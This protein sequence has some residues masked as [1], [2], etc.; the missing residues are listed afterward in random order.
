[1]AQLSEWLKV[2]SHVTGFLY[3][4]MY[5]HM[6]KYALFFRAGR[7]GPVSFRSE[8]YGGQNRGY[9]VFQHNKEQ[10]I[11]VAVSVDLYDDSVTFLYESQRRAGEPNPPLD[12]Y[13]GVPEMTETHREFYDWIGPIIAAMRKNWYN[14]M[15]CLSYMPQ[16]S[17]TESGSH[18]RLDHRVGS[19]DGVYG[20]RQAIAE[21]LK[22]SGPTFQQHLDR[23]RHVSSARIEVLLVMHCGEKTLLEHTE[24]PVDDASALHLDKIDAHIKQFVFYRSLVMGCDVSACVI[25]RVS[26]VAEQDVVKARAAEK[27][28]ADHV[29]REQADDVVDMVT[30]FL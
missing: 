5:R 21:F 18:I 8:Q 17:I 12:A 4:H 27:E 11:R 3:N 14:S 29:L 26:M 2:D 15:L 23:L 16:T 20:G 7:F 19:K 13:G 1:M 25:R 9:W 10:R 30:G 6:K 24:L 22:G 28:V